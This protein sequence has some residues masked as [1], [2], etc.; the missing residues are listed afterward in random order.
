[1]AVAW[2]HHSRALT[3][4]FALEEIV[5]SKSSTTGTKVFSELIAL[6]SLVLLERCKAAIVLSY[7]WSV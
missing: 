5:R 1:M 2:S 4:R 6:I 7:P 3:S